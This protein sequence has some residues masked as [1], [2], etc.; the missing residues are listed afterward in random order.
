MKVVEKIG[1]RKDHKCEQVE[2]GVF[3]VEVKSLATLE[4]LY[5]MQCFEKIG[6]SKS[7]EICFSWKT[8]LHLSCFA[9]ACV[10][11]QHFNKRIRNLTKMYCKKSDILT[12]KREKIVSDIVVAKTS[13]GKYWQLI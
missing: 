2:E 11:R 9:K 3:V 8:D 7:N 12:R 6:V 5:C 13:S 10:H 1:E 4:K